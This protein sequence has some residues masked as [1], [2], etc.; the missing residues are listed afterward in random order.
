MACRKHP[1]KKEWKEKTGLCDQCAEEEGRRIYDAQ[2]RKCAI[3]DTPFVDAC[4]NGR[5]PSEAKLDHD[6]D[7]GQI[8]GVLCDKCNRGLGFFKDDPNR[9]RAAMAYLKKDV[10]PTRSGITWRR[11]IFCQFE[12]EGLKAAVEKCAIDTDC[13]IFYGTS[14]DPDIH[15]CPAF[16]MIV[17]RNIVGHDLWREKVEFDDSTHDDIPCFIVDNIRDLP[18]PRQKYVY[19]FDLNNETTIPTIIKTITQMKTEMDKRLPDLFR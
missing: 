10:G 12:H 11:N 14:G 1:T 6:H 19:Q 2:N 4:L 17:D 16:V 15:A 18:L 5:V 3:C 8:R 13:T 7:T 9:L